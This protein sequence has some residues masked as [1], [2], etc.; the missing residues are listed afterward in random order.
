MKRETKRKK[1][2]KRA[3]RGKSL[4]NKTRKTKKFTQSKCKRRWRG[5]E[6]DRGE[7][8]NFNLQ[9]ECQK[10]IFIIAANKLNQEARRGA[11]MEQ[12]FRCCGIRSGVM[13]MSYSIYKTRT[14]QNELRSSLIYSQHENATDLRF[15][16]LETVNETVRW[17]LVR[18]R[19]VW[20][21]YG[22]GV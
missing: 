10:E 6:T 16:R 18:G 13:K 12:S 19:I 22:G 7:T 3:Q 2:R 11:K 4:V 14:H 15:T 5:E 8:I 17:S 9:L 21:C 20:W 1:T